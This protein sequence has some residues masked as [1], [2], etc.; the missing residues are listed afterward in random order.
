MKVVTKQEYEE[1]K[2]NRSLLK[3]WIVIE[4]DREDKLIDD[5]LDCRSMIRTYKKLV[6]K[7][8]EIIFEYKHQEKME[9]IETEK[10]EQLWSRE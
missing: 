1:A 4:E 5:L 2:K 8:N 9:N 6:R 7:T 10:E 3:E